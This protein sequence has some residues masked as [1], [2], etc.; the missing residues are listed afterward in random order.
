[1]M[2]LHSSI[3]KATEA[4][5]GVQQEN[6]VQQNCSPALIN[7]GQ[8]CRIGVDCSDCNNGFCGPQCCGDGCN[9]TFTSCRKQFEQV[10][11]SFLGAWP[12]G[13]RLAKAI[14]L[15]GGCLNAWENQ[16]MILWEQ[17]AQGEYCMPARTAHVD[18]YRL[19]PD[20][21]L[22]M[23]YRLTREEQP[24]PYQLNVGDEIRVESAADEKLD[25][26]LLLQPDGTIT[27]YLLG[28]VHASNLTVPQLREKI[29]QEYKKY[30]KT[31]SITVTPLRVNSKLDDLRN[32][33]DARYGTGGLNRSARVAPDG[34]ISLPAVGM[35]QAQGLTLPEL[36]TELREA[37]RREVE[38]IEVIPVLV[39][40]APRYVY[41]L[42]EVDVPGRFQL[43]GP[44]SLMQALAM[45]GSWKI[46]ANLR[47]VVVFRRDSNWNLKA[48]M[49]NI[50]PALYGKQPCPDGNIWLADS[51][52]VVVP[53]HPILVVDEIIDLVFTRGIY[54]VFPVFFNYNFGTYGTL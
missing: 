36:R 39:Q 19:R 32:A 17:Y 41:V 3:A 27:L 29:N 8:Q 25:R 16:R 31:P 28:Q 4:I 21:M 7:S 14:D 43:D 9:N 6:G 35:V 11:T 48:T 30:Y 20:D 24:N 26:D 52:V 2:I 53:K 15:H 51:D 34:T 46:G 49:V 33:V 54:G 38:G 40:R 1:M 22:D 23:V 44:T 47:Q 13:P 50:H 18:E 37:Y 10:D 45:S 42:G 5:Y 12:G